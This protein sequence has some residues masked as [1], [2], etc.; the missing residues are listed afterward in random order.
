ML[1]LFINGRK[2]RWALVGF[3]LGLLTAPAFQASAAVTYSSVFTFDQSITSISGGVVASGDSL[4]GT[5][6]NSS[7]TYG[8]AI[9]KASIAGGA[10]QTI[11]QLSDK[12]GYTPSAGLLVGS[13]GNL[14]GSTVY[15]ARSV[16]S[17]QSGAGT[18]F[19]VAQ[20]GTGFLKLHTFDVNLT[21]SSE[22][23]GGQAQTYT[24][25]ADGIYPSFP[26]IEDGTYLYGVTSS[27]GNNGTGVIFRLQR[28]GGGF[29]VLHHFAAQNSSGGGIEGAFPSG[30]LLLS[31]GRLYGT[32]DN[33]GGNLYRLNS[34]T[35][36]ATVI[37]TQG[38]GTVFS[39]NTDGSG[40][41]TI[42]NFSAL[43]DTVDS[44]SSDQR[45]CWR[46]W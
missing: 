31:N 24:K 33:G 1:N 23:V 22:A 43:T 15:G 29:V 40:F 10:P 36:E 16:F 34:V 20:N 35:T 19:R 25:N 46:K 42:Y 18:L 21:S 9:Y 39:L 2:N 17:V 45:Q 14:Y 12:D 6:T 13:D 38:T 26:L 3:G 5:L 8:G 41:Q 27:G 44:D 4:F 11:F 30:P 7:F 37:T 32:T 28:G